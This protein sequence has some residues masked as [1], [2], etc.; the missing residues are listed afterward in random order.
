MRLL[1]STHRQLL[2]I[3]FI[4]S[5]IGPFPVLRAQSPPGPGQPI[6]IK[7]GQPNIWSL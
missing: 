6:I 2:T 4:A 1:K 7:F 5:M 3:L